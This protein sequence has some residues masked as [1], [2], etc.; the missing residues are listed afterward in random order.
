MKASA[1][2]DVF[3]I[4]TGMFVRRGSLQFPIFSGFFVD[5]ESKV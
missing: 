5:K 2:A 4:G 1:Q 3:F